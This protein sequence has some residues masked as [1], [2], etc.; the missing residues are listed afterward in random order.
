MAILRK[1]DKAGLRLV[2]GSTLSVLV[3]FGC[4]AVAPASLEA[5]E[6]TESVRSPIVLAN[7]N[8]PASEDF[9]VFIGRKKN[10]DDPSQQHNC[11]GAL[12]A[13]NLV[14]TVKHCL[15]E[16]QPS[17]VSTSYCEATGEPSSAGTGA[18]LTG[19]FPADNLEIYAGPDGRKRSELQLTPPTALGK[20]VIDDGSTVLCSHDFG[21]VVLDRPITDKPIARLRLAKRPEPALTDLVLTGWGR[22]GLKSGGQMSPI[23]LRR[24]GIT[25]QR[26]GAVEPPLHPTGTLMP[27]TFETGPAGCVGDSGGPLFD[28]ANGNAVLGVLSRAANTVPD[29][30]DNGPCAPETVTNIYMNVTDFP[31]HLRRAFKAAGAEPWMEGQ[32]SA[33]YLRF[34]DACLSDLEC[35]GG[36]CVGATP[37]ATGSCNVDCAKDGQTCPSGYV[38]GAGGSCQTP[39]PAPTTMPPVAQPPSAEDDR[40]VGASGS[41][42]SIRGNGPRNVGP[43]AGWLVGAI[44][45]CAARRRRIGVERRFRT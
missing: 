33:G 13:P 41:G 28:P 15:H 10:P 17:V 44:A 39:Q 16:Y 31:E 3:S 35:E 22:V 40:G 7:G 24:G 43:F 21:Y 12:V 27:K 36:L 42:C 19:T 30:V 1:T 32:G 14:L 45:A 5:D 34:G 23:R 38:C 29:D 6:S 25:I 11:G 26:V 4:G 9:V 18:Y 20:E 2:G 37:S 8:S